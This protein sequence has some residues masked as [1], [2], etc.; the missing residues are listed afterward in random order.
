[1]PKRGDAYLTRRKF[2][3]VGSAGLAASLCPV[4]SGEYQPVRRVLF[5]A[6]RSSH[7]FGSHQHGA[8]CQFLADCLNHQGHFRAEVISDQ[9]PDDETVFDGVD[10]V[11]IYGDGGPGHI[12]AGHGDSL[13]RLIQRGVG[14]GMLHYALVPPTE[15]MYSLFLQGLGGYY[16]PGW[17]VNPTWDARFARLPAHPIM[18]GVR[19]FAIKDE[20][21]Y[22]MRFVPDQTNVQPLLSVLPP[23]S[24]LARPD[25]PHSNNPAVRKEVLELGQAQHLAWAYERPRGGR[26]F[27]LTGMH[28]HWNWGHRDLRTMILNAIAWLTGLEIP[29]GGLGSVQPSAGQLAKYVGPTPANLDL[30]PIQRMMDQWN[31]RNHP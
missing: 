4:W 17:S 26:G 7:A 20:W 8:G 21:Y 9:W 13:E 11:I 24:T 22:H 29:T 5:I 6:G 3:A 2:M 10:A 19:P 30:E 18:R 1:M 16:E 27:G 12:V 15:Q 28:F 14:L 31:G 23:A 25:G